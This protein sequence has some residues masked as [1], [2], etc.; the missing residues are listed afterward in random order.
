[1]SHE[2]L[3]K[4]EYYLVAFV[5]DS[6]DDKEQ[7]YCLFSPDFPEALSQGSSIKECMEMATDVL[8]VTVEAYAEEK[9]K[10]PSPCDIETARARINKRMEEYGISV[11]GEILYQYIPVIVPD[12]T[13]SK[14]RISLTKS[15]LEE[16]DYRA[17]LHGM[18]RSKFIVA[19]C[20]AYK[21]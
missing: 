2:V 11:D 6:P 4:M 9:R 16:I 1:M 18:T 8:Q 21:P 7:G 14:I 10:I 13:L 17:K 5:P 15:V 12:V 20:R 19:A 3:I